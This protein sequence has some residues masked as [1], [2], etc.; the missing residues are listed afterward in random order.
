MSE[1]RGVSIRLRVLSKDSPRA[2]KTRDGKEHKVVD[3]KVGDRTG[4][5]TLTL[6]DDRADQVEVGDLIEISNGYVNRFKGR[7]ILNIGEFGSLE[8]IEDPAFPTAEEILEIRRSRQSSWLKRK[9]MDFDPGK[10]QKNT[11]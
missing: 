4:T 1:V 9:K 10:R 8:R 11:Q 5:I 2:A 3:A 7:L 6:W